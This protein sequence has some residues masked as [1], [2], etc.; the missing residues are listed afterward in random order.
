MTPLRIVIVFSFCVHA[1]LASTQM[2][3]SLHVLTVFYHAR[4][5]LYIHEYCVRYLVSKLITKAEPDRC[6]ARPHS[7]QVYCHSGF[8]HIS[9]HSCSMNLLALI[10][11]NS[12]VRVFPQQ[13]SDQQCAT[14][15]NEVTSTICLELLFQLCATAPAASV[16]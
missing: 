12:P 14:R 3:P 7:C 13:M 4:A 11:Y 16:A 10:S 9:S 15:N 6:I 5:P 1:K 8:F 2:K